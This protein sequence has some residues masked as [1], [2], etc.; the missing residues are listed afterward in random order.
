VIRALA[1][2]GGGVR[3]II[4]AA[5]LAALEARTGRRVH[6]L[7]DVV[8]GT[9]AGAILALGLASPA[10]QGA[11]ALRDLYLDRGGAIFPPAAEPG[12][13]RDPEPLRAELAARLGDAPMSAALVPVLAV[14][15]DALGRRP[16]VFRGGGLDPGEVGDAPMLRAGLASSAYPGVFPAVPHVGADGVER[17]CVDG[18]LIANDPALVAWSAARALAPDDDVLLV[19]LGTGAGPAADAAEAPDPVALAAA[20]AP[21]LVRDALRRALGGRY[22]RI[23]ADLGPGAATAFDDAS[24]AALAA[25]GRAADALVAREGARLDALAALLTG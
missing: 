8:A 24:P 5:V 16:A 9:S 12:G 20:A 11:A 4:P 19:S 21:Q 2:D 22:V 15:C 14:A 1:I 25:L 6:E 17:S 18:G 10:P 7:V 23:Q 3:G 13:P